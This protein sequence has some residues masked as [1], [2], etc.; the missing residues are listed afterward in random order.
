LSES[1][2]DLGFLRELVAEAKKLR[3]QAELKVRKREA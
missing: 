3:E 2:S 1:E